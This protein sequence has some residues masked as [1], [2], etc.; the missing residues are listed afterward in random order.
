MLFTYVTWRA[1]HVVEYARVEMCLKQRQ[2]V[3]YEFKIRNVVLIKVEVVIFT[4][5]ECS[6]C[7]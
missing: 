7:H 4:I 3:K 1:A 6:T 5:D 2:E